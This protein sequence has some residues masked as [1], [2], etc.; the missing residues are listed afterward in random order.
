MAE[1]P[2]PGDPTFVDELFQLLEQRIGLDRETLG[3]RALESAVSE[4]LGELGIPWEQGEQYLER[5]RCEPPLL[6]GLVEKIVVNETWFRRDGKPF[7][8]LT[9]YAREHWRAQHSPQRLR[10]LSIPC[11]TGEEPYSIA[12]SLLEAGLQPDRF[13]IDALDISQVALCKAAEGI[14][15]S[16]SFRHNTPLWRDTYFRQVDTDLWRLGEGVRR[17]VQFQ[18]ANLLDFWLTQPAGIYQVIFSRNLLIYLSQE[19]KLQ[20]LTCFRHLLRPGG[21]LFVGHAEMLPMLREHFQPVPEASTF[22]YTMECP[23]PQ[24][25]PQ[26]VELPEIASRTREANDKITSRLRRIAGK[27]PRAIVKDAA[28]VTPAEPAPALHAMPPVKLPPATAETAG[29]EM[30]P[31]EA[32]PNADGLCSEAQK[33]ADNGEYT[34][35]LYKAIDALHENATHVPARHL[36][37][38]LQQV[39]GDLAGAETEFRRVLYLEPAHEASMTQLAL[40]LRQT[41]RE[42]EAAQL[43]RRLQRRTRTGRILPASSS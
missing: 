3:N 26:P 9:A 1:E 30:P 2:E 39:L 6:Q 8:F 38:V 32:R 42:Q 24:R 10:L 40:L 19:A 34:Q 16:N 14:Y 29:G 43:Q 36:C 31:A 17:S 5:L 20:A 7:E 37:A 22:A 25:A 13:R 12:I 28:P 11:A 21:L 41:G 33:L 35:A 4:H 23:H 27:P 18:Q 15:S